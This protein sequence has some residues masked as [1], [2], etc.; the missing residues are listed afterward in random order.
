MGCRLNLAEGESI[1]A[2]LT[3]RDAIVVNSCAVT[4]EAVK[5][6]RQA[7]RRARRERPDAE[8]VVTGC[9]AQIDPHAFAAMPEVDRVIGNAEKLLP[10]AWASDAKVQVQDILAVRETA[11]HLAAS[12]STHARAFVEV[13]N[14]C[15]HR[16]T[17]CAIPFG[18]GNSRSVPAGAVIDRI[19]LLADAH[20][21]V[22]LTGVDL[23]SYGHDLPGAPTLG[24]L[25]ERVLKHVPKLRRLRLSS[26]DGIEVDDRLFALL[27]Q[28][29]RV[30]PH[31]H[32]SLQAGDDLILK[33]MKR[34]HARAQSVALAERLRVARPEIA[35]GAD[36]IAGFPTEDD[37]MFENTLALIADCG[38]VHAHIFPYSPRAGTPAAR[39]PQVA[40]ATIRDRAARLRAAAA[41]QRAHWLE[42][43]VGSRQQVLVERP[44][45]R[46][47]AGNF[48]EVRLTAPR[49]TGETVNV[50]IARVE[51][52]TLVA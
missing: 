25:V 6:T 26:L 2:L 51:D 40:H 50:T 7:I 10:Q 22:V 11:P 14:G 28:E 20:G 24:S 43:L 12:F 30:M 31:V 49:Q 41:E 45:D 8:L 1:R 37:T 36:L 16:C 39:M 27:T 4:N 44:G 13:Q 47:H 17:F 48:A 33:R 3:G 42:T 23:T 19:A 52:G 9:A 21:E 32:L 18:R 35:I 46:G 5:Q 29:P 34:R 38:V 15:D